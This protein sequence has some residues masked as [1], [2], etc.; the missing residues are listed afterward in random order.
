MDLVDY[1]DR[2]CQPQADQSVLNDPLL[3]AEV[4]PEFEVQR[5]TYNLCGWPMCS[6]KVRYCGNTSIP[7]FCC[8]KC[9]YLS[10]CL[11]QTLE[12]PKKKNTVGTVKLRFKEMQPPKRDNTVL[13]DSIEGMREPVGPYRVQISKLLSWV[14]GFPVINPVLTPNQI[15]LRKI[16]ETA[17]DAE[18]I[19]IRKDP[20]LHYFMC[21]IDVDDPKVITEAPEVFRYAFGFAM[22]ELSTGANMDPLF[23]KYNIP[24]Y[25]YE[26]II[27]C[28][29]QIPDPDQPE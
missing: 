6:N 5:N 17:A 28:L 20:Y 13:Y 23:S 2:F 19:N 11:H 29:N 22:I 4:L 8:D 25:L 3:T 24:L 1:V 21:N 16:V 14:G 18:K 27:E 12:T 26:D 10:A 9:R 15:E 7:L